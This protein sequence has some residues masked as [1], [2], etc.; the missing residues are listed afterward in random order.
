[1]TLQPD[2]VLLAGGTDG[3][4]KE[5]LLHNARMLSQLAGNPPIIV[6][7]N[8]AVAPEAAQILLDRGFEAVVVDN[9]MPE[10]NRINVEAAGRKIREIFINKIIEAKGFQQVESFMDG[11][12]MPTPAAV[13]NAA[14]L[15][16]EG[17]GKEAGWGELMA[18]D[19][20]G[21]TTDVYSVA[22]GAPTKDGIMWKGMPEPK[23]KRTVEGDL[24]MRH[25][26]KAAL[27][28][29]AGRGWCDHVEW[30]ALVRYVDLFNADP[31]YLPAREKEFD[32]EAKLGMA[33]V[34]M[35]VERHAG[36]L[37]TSYGP[38]GAVFLQHGKDLTRVK[39]VIG[40]G[41]IIAN[42]CSPE[43][44]FQKVC[45]DPRKSNLLKPKEPHFWLDKQQI[46]AALGLVAEIDADKALR[47]LKKYLVS[48]GGS[49]LGSENKKLPLEVFLKEREQVLKAWPAGERLTWMR[50]LVTSGN[51]RRVKFSGANRKKPRREALL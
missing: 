19:P 28:S 2:I 47:M 18:V 34:E 41:G 23:V 39:H 49:K 3:G 12:L 38:M 21:A 4:N 44:F 29:L 22:E 20:G 50:P 31:A 35:A 46:M 30:E 7:G 16:A 24:G 17:T 27:E 25:S 5:V 32:L 1:M 43:L 40:T 26:A 14:K 8:K 48:L 51:C 37:E 42:H 9:V 13:L 36:Y 6:A 11:I 33:I 45:F 10:L 15:L